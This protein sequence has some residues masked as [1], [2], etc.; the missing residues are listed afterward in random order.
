MN[1]RLAAAVDAAE[2]WAIFDPDPVTRS[3]IDRLVDAD[4]AELVALFDGR[5]S[6][7][8]AGLRAEVGPGPNRM[9]ALVVRQ[10]TVG[11]VEWLRGAH[12]DDDVTAPSIVIGFDARH[13]SAS[14]ARHAAAAARAAGA[15]VALAD[16]A[17]PTPI[18]AHAALARRADAAIVITA[19]HNPPA[20]NGYKL[21]VGDGMQI[22]PPAEGEIAAA[23]E[24]TAASWAGWA[25][26]V[27]DAMAELADP[28]DAT[29]WVE[30]HRQAAVAATAIGPTDEVRV[31]YTPMHGVGGEA[32]LA[33][34]AAAGLGPPLVVASQFEPDPTFPTVAFPNPEE[35][36]ALDEALAVA[37]ENDADLIVAHDPDADRLAIAARTH[38]GAMMP[39]SG[40]QLG[41]VLAD[42]VLAGLGD[43]AARALVARSVVSSR[44]LDAIAAH[45]GATCAVTLTGF[46][47]IARAALDHPDRAWCFGYEEAIG[48][49][50]GTH[51][52]DKDGITA[53]LVA[54]DL[55]NRLAAQG[56]K[57]WD[58][59]D[60]LALRHG[61]Y[62]SGPVTLRFDDDPTRI[63][64]VVE[65]LQ[66]APPTDLLGSP[67][68]AG[69]IGGGA[70]PPTDGVEIVADDASRVIVRPSGTE[71]KVKAYLEVIE[72]VAGESM[73]AEAQAVAE[74]RIDRLA[75]QVRSLLS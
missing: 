20:D 40:D 14:F 41:A 9:N 67:A 24:E 75:A 34:F 61:V 18:V 29:G 62:R 26:L 64:A 47:W 53:A 49:C 7:G 65:R 44:M 13:D 73:L 60:E 1:D 33:A 42:H 21:Y 50:I 17:T 68:A 71:P 30:A 63:A 4:S 58:R 59:L 43:H 70:L 46:K 52:R 37:A 36:G 32:T 25:P 15:R 19:S 16:R 23:I 69:P 12:G 55:A 5:L 51:V 35:P 28:H 45:H 54:V 22:V 6:F 74:A 31:V 66:A 10:T 8:T 38:A 27:D 57:L 2:R 39:L 72:P 3:A 48:Y 56:R 11:V